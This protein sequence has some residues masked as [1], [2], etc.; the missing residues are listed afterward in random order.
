M[1]AAV[2]FDIA[3]EAFPLMLL[4][5]DPGTGSLL[6]SIVM[7]F[8]TAS[9]FVA[10][11]LFY[12]LRARLGMG[13]GA[14][15]EDTPAGLAIYSEGRQYAALF[16]PILAGLE[17]RGIPCLYLSSDK[18]DPLLDGGF[19]NVSARCIGR[20]HA[21]WG[22][23]NTLRADVCLMTT[24][25][26][27]VMQIRRSRH[28]RHYSHVIHSPTDKAFNR[29]YS[30]D[31]FD[32]VFICGPHQRQTLE[33]LEAL[34]R[35][36]RKSLFLAGCVYYDE[37]LPAIGRL[38][39]RSDGAPGTRVLVAPTWGK[40]GLLSRY[41]ARLVR[42]LLEAGYQ[43]VLRPH[44]QSA[45][46]EPDLL[47]AL[48]RELGD[49]PLLEWDEHPDPLAAMAGADLLISDISGIVF[50]FAFLTEKPV[51]TVAFTPEKRG[52]EANDLPYEPWE[53]RVL[54]EIGGKIGEEDL[55]CLSA[56]VERA[57]SD[58]GRRASIRALRD[59][60]VAHFGSSAEHV[61]DGLARLLTNAPP[62][63]GVRPA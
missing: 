10:K 18:D 47:K 32:S 31:Y 27:D 15:G 35:T 60:Y 50:D 59:E 33:Y 48:K 43:V 13:S 11:G 20:G 21:A 8:A 51:L 9:F 17:R 61:V 55:E 52:F 63:S 23:L 49:S 54:D 46:S 1:T 3:P 6:F 62:E 57:L 42:P 34:R 28:V 5:L 44:P 29:P 39:P 30:F 19:S 25:G 56:L 12:K 41:G 22:Y 37:M 53:L 16:R 7:G 40:N 14:A 45:L 38:A 58:S 36:P 2:P 24:P 26:L 4:Y